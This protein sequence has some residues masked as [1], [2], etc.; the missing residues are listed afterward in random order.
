MRVRGG[1][2]LLAW[3][4]RIATCLIFGAVYA[5]GW[6]FSVTGFGPAAI[7]ASTCIR[8]LTS[9]A[10]NQPIGSRVNKTGARS[11]TART[12]LWTAHFFP[13]AYFRHGLPPLPRYVDIGI[14]DPRLAAEAVIKLASGMRASLGSLPLVLE[15]ELCAPFVCDAALVQE[16]ALPRHLATRFTTD[17]AEMAASFPSASCCSNVLTWSDGGPLVAVP[18]LARF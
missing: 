6:W 1:G 8:L 9:A 3:Q 15:V 4:L 2:A 16:L 13:P 14:V 7:D 18:P 12:V 11:C 5:W 17:S 10:V